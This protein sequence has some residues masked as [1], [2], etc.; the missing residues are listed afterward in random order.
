[1]A[2]AT[3]IMV[4]TMVI[5]ATGAKVS[6]DAVRLSIP[7]GNEPG[8]ESIDRAVG[9]MFH[10]VDPSTTYFFL[11]RRCR[12]FRLRIVARVGWEPWRSWTRRKKNTN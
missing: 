11:A 6:F 9:V 7:F 4:R 3:T 10:F 5:F 8:F 12:A 2:P 1:M